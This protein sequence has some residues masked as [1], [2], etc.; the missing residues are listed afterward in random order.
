MTSRIQLSGVSSAD[1]SNPKD[2]VVQGPFLYV[3]SESDTGLVLF[4]GTTV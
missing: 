4:M 3:I 2:L 1:P